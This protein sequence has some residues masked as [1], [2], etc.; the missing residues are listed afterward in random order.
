[1]RS[2]ASS[3]AAWPRP[4]T[5]LLRCEQK[6]DPVAHAERAHDGGDVRLHGAFAGAEPVRD[7]LVRMAVGDQCQDLLLPWREHAVPLAPAEALVRWRQR[8]AAAG[9]KR[10]R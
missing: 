9:H 8:L 3:S 7:L 4:D 10:P 2:C 6:L 1:M 5:A